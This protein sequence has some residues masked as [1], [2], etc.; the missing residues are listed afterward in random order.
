MSDIDS[1]S[2]CVYNKAEIS[3]KMICKGVIKMPKKQVTLTD[4]AN[5]C[6][7]STVTVSKA[8]S[9][10]DGVG[11]ELRERIREAARTMGYIPRAGRLSELSGNIGV[12]IPNKFITS[13]GTFYWMLFN[14]IVERLKRDNLSCIQEN[15]GEEEEKNLSVPNILAN[16]RI[17]G[18]IS[19][20][21]LST[22]Y[23]EMLTKHT[24]NIVLLD[25]H[26]PD[27]DLDCVIS[28]G[29]GGGYK[30]TS[31][32]IRN[33]HKEIGFIGNRLATSS[34]YDRYT[35]YMRAMLENG[36]PVRDEWILDDRKKDNNNFGIIEYPEKMPSAFVCNCDET[37]YTAV[38]DL[39][40]LGYSV[41]EDISVVGYD[42]Y[43]FSQMSEPTITTIDVDTQL[44]AD[45]AV[46]LLIERICG[47]RS[48]HEI[49][50]VSGMLVCKDSV[51]LKDEE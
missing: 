20:G 34:I 15:I 39:K 28:D 6:G 51:R 44:M 47:M 11:D 31:Y 18:L 8:L 7:T 40:S 10:K 16:G 43:V 41:P 36:L 24:D 32:L 9:G 12:I 3:S 23:V 21:Q 37:A 2:I 22:E 46:S 17:S 19:L 13:I 26:L 30:L 35:G 42:N 5:A 29:F 1:L 4:I 27:K 50:T 49:I 48:G 38:K 45:K 25:Y 14:K 33:G